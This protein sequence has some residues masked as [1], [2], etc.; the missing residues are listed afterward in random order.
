MSKV[1]ILEQTNNGT[2]LPSKAWLSKGIENL[3]ARQAA[4][5]NDIVF[6]VIIIGSGY[7]GSIAAH[8]LSKL[9]GSDEL[10]IGVLERGREFLPGSFPSDMN[11]APTE[12]RNTPSNGS[13]PRGNLE[14]LF[15]IRINE[16]LNIL[17]ANGLGGGSLINAGVMARA[18][19]EVFKSE[20]WP[21]QIKAQSLAPF[22]TEA[23]ELLGAFNNDGTNRSA[24]TIF[25]HEEFNRGI[26]PKKYESLKRLSQGSH[27]K[28]TNITVNMVD[29]KTT[30]AGI[31]LN[32]C[33]LC[34]DCASGCN[35]NAKIS[36]DKNLLALAAKNG[37]EIFTGV[38]VLCLDKLETSKQQSLWSIKTVY[39]DESLRSRQQS[40]YQTIKA[41]QVIVAAGALGSTEILT[42]SKKNGLALSDQ[43]GTR[44][45]S[46][47]DMMLVSY[48]QEQETNAIAN[49]ATAH[50][51]RKVG[52]TITSMLDLRKHT[53][54]EQKMVIQEM[55]VPAA[56]SH[57]FKELYSTVYAIR[58]IWSN[59]TTAH[60][61]GSNFSDP[62]AIS[63]K[64]TQNT[65]LYAAMGND[66]ANGKLTFK[67]TDSKQHEGTL[68]VEWP[69]LKHHT[70][71]SQQLNKL[72]TLANSNTFS[73]SKNR[74]GGMII[75]NPFWQLLAPH[76][77]ELLNL[78]KGPPLTVHPLG[79]CPM[80]ASI[81]NGVCNHQGLVYDPNSGGLHKGLMVL[82]GAIIPSAVG[83]N[84][85]LTISAVCLKSI[86]ELIDNGAFE[87]STH[88]NNNNP[89]KRAVSLTPTPPIIRSID[90]LEANAIKATKDT[91]VSI[92]ERLVG[93][94]QLEDN[95]GVDQEAVI[96]ISLWSKPLALKN[97]SEHRSHLR[98]EKTKLI[99][100]TDKVDS[101]SGAPLSQIRIYKR[102]DWDVLRSEQSSTDIHEV[103]LD[104]AAQFIGSIQGHLSILGRAESYQA[105][106]VINSF[107]AWLF[108]RGI[109][110]VY[111][112]R[113][114]LEWECSDLP[115]RQKSVYQ[116]LKLFSF[117]IG[118]MFKSFSRAGEI[119]TLNYQLSIKEP[120]KSS[121]FSYFACSN[122]TQG[123]ST[124][125]H[126][127]VG[128]KKL[129]Y[130]RR[131]NPWLQLSEVHLEK[132]PT[133]P[134][135]S[136]ELIQRDKK[137]RLGLRKLFIH[138]PQEY[139]RNKEAFRL[140]K[141]GNILSLDLNYLAKVDAPILQ[142]TEQ[143]NQ[144]QALLDIA[145]FGA[146]FTRML[147]G[148]HFYSFRAPETPA[149]RTVK[150]A[151]STAPGLPTPTIEKILVGNIPEDKVVAL[152]KG[153]PVTIV[154]THF[155]NPN[156]DKPPVLMIHGYSASSTTFAH[157]SL[158]NSLAKFCYEQGRDVWLLDCRTSCAQD[159]SRYPWSFESVAQTDI[160]K[161]ISHIYDFYKSQQKIDIISHCMG[162][163][164]LGMSILK[165][166]DV[167]ATDDTDCHGS[168]FFTKRLNRIVLSQATPA[169]KFTQDNNFRSFATSYL[170]E[171]VPDDYQFQPNGNRASTVLDRILYTLPYPSKEFD[172]LNAPFTP[173][174]RA[175]FARTR[176]RMDA[177]F[178]RTFELN[179]I[180]SETL[181]CIDDFF[182]P[183]NVNTIIQ[184]S[185][186]ATSNIMADSKGRNE[187][188]SRERL[189]RYWG[190]IPTMSFHSKNNGLIDYSTGERTKRIFQEAGTPYHSVLI[191]DLKYGHQDSI[192][193]PNA[194]KDIFPYIT[195]FLDSE[196]IKSVTNSQSKPHINTAT[197]SHLVIEAPAYGPMLVNATAQNQQL[198]FDER[199][200]RVSFGLDMARAVEPI[201]V[202]LPVNISDDGQ[203][204][205]LAN[206]SSQTAH[207]FISHHLEQSRKFIVNNDTWWKVIE[208]PKTLLQ[209]EHY[210][211]VATFVIYD[212][213]INLCPETILSNPTENINSATRSHTS[214]LFSKHTQKDLIKAL[215]TLFEQQQ[216]Y[217]HKYAQGVIKHPKNQ[218]GPVNFALGSCQY[219]GGLLDKSLAYKSYQQLNEL[220]DSDTAQ[221]PTFMT[222][223]GDQIYADAT[224]G[225]LDPSTR[226]DQYSRPYL[227]LYQQGQVRSVMRKLP[228]FNMLDDH[229]LIDNWEPV[230][231]N[232][233]QH[234]K[235]EDI[236]ISGVRAFLKYQRAET[237]AIDHDVSKDSLW[238][239]FSQQQ[240]DFF[241]CDTRT[242][243]AAR[244][245]ENIV[246]PGTTIL[247][248]NQHQALERWLLKPTKVSAKFI[249]SSSLFLPRHNTL[250]GADASMT[251]AIRT[252]SWDGY[253]VS[254][255]R[256]LA[257]LVDQQKNNIVF[258]S[259]DDHM[260]CFA[261]IQITNLDD[262]KTVQTWSAH[263]PGLYTPFPFANARLD[264]FEGIFKTKLNTKS[265]EF[266]FQHNET[267]YHCRVNA[268]FGHS[269]TSQIALGPVNIKTLG[270]FLLISTR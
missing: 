221:K 261:D 8:E 37:V 94:T 210:H 146:Y 141:L 73:R 51:K 167:E 236:R 178:S 127:I 19:D 110:D 250:H 128:S 197:S 239:E 4:S 101:I 77:M 170:K 103:A 214:P 108:N 1:G 106:R 161:A 58:S 122:P 267:S 52:P 173:S 107:Y 67:H 100:D 70:L 49:P 118:G 206:N 259:G 129:H 234:E 25:N 169:I 34:G 99:V 59:D 180:S 145:S 41:K 217:S 254:L 253:P 247:G 112:S 207:E 147:V 227:K 14:G 116:R 211:G 143:E 87:K 154:L 232:S 269:E 63:P 125:I 68:Q 203:Q 144:V 23:E 213:L 130:S 136:R 235:L 216:C 151:A 69:E 117:Y 246:L 74:V 174:K 5:S 152:T 220:L 223:L 159:S 198:N 165:Y 155:A 163:I 30:D 134:R 225:L 191:N 104:N 120:L 96:E 15:D 189:Q 139:L 82:D 53:D 233:N 44:F 89:K 252:D 190:N 33:N 21:A 240:H 192:I 172:T 204:L 135:R 18:D 258:L 183:I 162:A 164:M 176:H 3:Y 229:E 123:V 60:S 230:S 109:R 194:H 245:A 185:Q 119:R 262:Q 86:R 126:S 38:S 212:D 124:L 62:A 56:A 48:N 76:S 177:F 6:D 142:I 265:S 27:F 179:N 133:S 199:N 168:D 205:L 102:A 150:R 93:F 114:P 257:F 81:E 248:Q 249:L 65:S 215:S 138:N 35:N 39:T 193:S 11:D 72:T 264:D 132:L 32:A 208:V 270:G 242:Q 17:Q 121:D 115:Q 263:C 66:G 228:S 78:K 84:P 105:S 226:F 131:S 224:A 16:D 260:A 22:Y 64:K 157:K 31:K 140:K 255:H 182:G 45:S 209:S 36:L 85:A 54:V 202:F 111:Q 244:T 237:R 46:N 57:F 95:A 75:P 156:A 13:K 55:A 80:S 98:A 137:N 29:Q 90:Q 195:D 97:F 92:T 71:F 79:G 10:H 243:R 219:P 7:G 251:S 231:N 88:A 43:L 61:E 153:D 160:P 200:I 222:L 166:A 196:T 149:P 83:I 218:S 201:T 113:T 186:F 238:Y 12:L 175:N 20:Y 171:L 268:R 40:E 26:G 47:G 2:P 42:R 158:P 28:D 148:I 9:N 50:S 266:N 184:A 187:Y 256:L 241:M 91:Q 188:L 181:D 24:N